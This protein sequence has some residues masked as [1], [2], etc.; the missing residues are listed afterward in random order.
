MTSESP[1]PKREK[2]RSDPKTL[3]RFVEELSWLLSSYEELDFKALGNMSADLVS[4]SRSS[5]E[6]LSRSQRPPTVRLLV[7][8]LPNFLTDE[9]LFPSNEDIVEF[10]QTALD[11]TITRW[12]KRS[13]YELIGNIVVHINEASRAKIERLMAV[14][15]LAL[16]EKSITRQKMTSDRRSGRSWNEVIQS[17]LRDAG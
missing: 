5:S 14:L 10:A 3:A 11:I 6:L 8:I 16:D 15:E 2:K 1:R 7:G 4:F 17:L 13:R 9:D 12:Q